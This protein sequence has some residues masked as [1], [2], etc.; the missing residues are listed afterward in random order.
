MAKLSDLGLSALLFAK[1]DATPTTLA[2]DTNNCRTRY[3]RCLFYSPHNSCEHVSVDPPFYLAKLSCTWILSSCW[4]PKC[5]TRNTFAFLHELCPCVILR[6]M[7]IQMLKASYA[8]NKER[9]NAACFRSQT[10]VSAL[11]LSYKL[12]HASPK[13][14]TLSFLPMS[15]AANIR[16]YE[17]HRTLDDLKGQNPETHGNPFKNACCLTALWCCCFVTLSL[18]HGFK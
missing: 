12:A 2:G 14:C 11:V 4:K 9:D 3:K 8:L 18:F 5:H 16:Q 17:Q 10:F 15:N 7:F 6:K 1:F 13:A